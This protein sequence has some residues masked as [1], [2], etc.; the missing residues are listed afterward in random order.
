MRRAKVHIT[1]MPAPTKSRL[2]FFLPFPRQST[3]ISNY[4]AIK[5]PN[6]IVLNHNSFQNINHSLGDT[7]IIAF[8]YEYVQKVTNA[9]I[10]L[11]MK[12]T[13]SFSKT[14]ASTPI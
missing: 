2:S 13:W 12:T 14:P 3:L 10:K 5:I 6:E 7:S 1:S 4:V 8:A 9:L 11:G